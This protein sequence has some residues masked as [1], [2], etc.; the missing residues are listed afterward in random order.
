MGVPP[1]PIPGFDLYA[2]LEVAPTATRETIDAAWRSLVKRHHPDADLA[3]EAREAAEARI[4][5]LNVAHDWLTDPVRRAR[6]D[7]ERR[8]EQPAS[9]GV[10]PPPVEPAADE[11]DWARVRYEA[12]RASRAAGS[13]RPRSLMAS[14]I[15]AVALGIVAIAVTLGGVF[16]VMRLGSTGGPPV[17]QPAPTA[18]LPTVAG[19]PE[20]D[21]AAALAATLPD[22]VAGIRLSGE[23]ATGAEVFGGDE[24]ELD[25]LLASVDASGEDLIGAYKA[26]E[27][28][29]GYL[30]VV[31]M[32]VAT[33]PGARL[34][35]AF[36]TTI[37]RDAGEPVTWSQA[38]LGGRTVLVSQDAYDPTIVAYLLSSTD[39]VYV[40][41]SPT[42]SVADAAIRALP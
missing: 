41:I 13:S 2:E 15:L 32:Q 4:R 42:E 12:D 39:A 33:V 9:F 11:T 3:P 20:P 25:A 23:S 16:A 30:T 21:R 18:A 1:E 6:Y 28:E 37:E 5:R 29:D 34:A 36:R 35:D 24:A 22:S 27:F 14:P 17:G 26:G 38:T 40:V 31:A 19:T 10:A 8:F 7:L